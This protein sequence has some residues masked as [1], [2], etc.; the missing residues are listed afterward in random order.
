MDDAVTMRRFEGFRDLACDG[1][2]FIVRQRTLGESISECGPVDQ[3]HDQRTHVAG[4][5][6]AVHVRDVRVVERG[7]H[8]RFPLEPRQPIACRSRTPRATP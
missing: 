8:V 5:G 3:F 7:E 2:R 6:D 1:D 4:V